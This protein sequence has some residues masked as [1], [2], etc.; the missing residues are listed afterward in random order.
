MRNPNGYFEETLGL[1]SNLCLT[2]KPIERA[3][4]GMVM[5]P[6]CCVQA[7]AGSNSLCQI[8]CVKYGMK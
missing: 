2:T 3:S 1:D 8:V 7:V 4:K 6:K 5:V